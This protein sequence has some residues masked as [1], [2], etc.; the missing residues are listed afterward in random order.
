MFSTRGGDRCRRCSNYSSENQ[1]IIKRS[2]RVDSPPTEQ[3][4]VCLFHECS[5]C[6]GKL[7]SWNSSASLRVHYPDFLS[8]FSISLSLSLCVLN[9]FDHF[10]NEVLFAG[11]NPE[12]GITLEKKPTGL[13]HQP[14]GLL[15]KTISH[16]LLRTMLLGNERHP[17]MIQSSKVEDNSQPQFC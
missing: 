9:I 11:V 2:L 10:I 14:F 5:F 3:T 13:F 4:A 1:K 16:G 17:F 12:V 7:W 6:G 8:F 15:Q